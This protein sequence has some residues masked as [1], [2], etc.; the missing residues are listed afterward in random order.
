MMWLPDSEKILK[1]YLYILT[2]FMNVTDR[3]IP[4]DGIGHAYAYH[5]AAKI[6]AL[7]CMLQSISSSANTTQSSSSSQAQSRCICS[8][9]IPSK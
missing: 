7:E 4:G 8:L 2:Q 9:L 1:I 6:Q 5:H 3:Q